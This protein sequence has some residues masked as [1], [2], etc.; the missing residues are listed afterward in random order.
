MDVDCAGNLLSG[1][2]GIAVEQVLRPQRDAGDAEAALHAGGGDET[3]REQVAVGGIQ[4]LERQ[5]VVTASGPG[6]HGAADLRVAVHQHQAAAALPLRRAPVLD[7]RHAKPLAQHVQQRFIGARRRADPPPVQCEINQFFHGRSG[8]RPPVYP[9]PLLCCDIALAGATLLERP[10]R[11]S[12][13]KTQAASG[14]RAASSAAR[15]NSFS[16]YS[17]QSC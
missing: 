2:A 5:D 8:A 12:A 13:A 10:D 3:A 9:P 11:V 15:C 16:L 14:F 1:R 6:R 4:S 7:R 17:V